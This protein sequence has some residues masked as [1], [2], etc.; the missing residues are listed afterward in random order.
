MF[1]LDDDFQKEIGIFDM[2]NDAKEKMI[3]N[4]TKIINDRVLIKMS[5]QITDEKTNELENITENPDEAKRWLLEN[6][7]NYTTSQ[8]FVE[9]K[10]QM[11]PEVN[12]DAMFAINKWFATNLPTY[13]QV[14][15]ATIEE[16]KNELK[17][18]TGK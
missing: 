3:A 5:D 13:P 16:V 1:Q 15:Q 2:P 9:F 10:K 11:D 6:A 7:P 14:L 12:M 17:A 4:I 8:E 18:V